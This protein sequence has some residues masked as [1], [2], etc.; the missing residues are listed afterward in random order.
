MLKIVLVTA[1]MAVFIG[2][3]ATFGRLVGYWRDRW[4]QDMHDAPA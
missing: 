3:G 1:M 4:F 2:I